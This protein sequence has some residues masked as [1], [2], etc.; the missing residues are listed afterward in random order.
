MLTLNHNFLK[1]KIVTL[2]QNVT[3]KMRELEITYIKYNVS[4]LFLKHTFS[5]LWC[6]FSNRQNFL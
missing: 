6:T 2:P 4:N 1:K 3:P 5:Y